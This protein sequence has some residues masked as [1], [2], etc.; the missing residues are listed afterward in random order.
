MLLASA[1]GSIKQEMT[2]NMLNMTETEVD[3]EGLEARVGDHDSTA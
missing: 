2:L 1:S 3:V